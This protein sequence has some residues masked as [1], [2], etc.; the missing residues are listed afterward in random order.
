MGSPGNGSLPREP[1]WGSAAGAM[2]IR[3]PMLSRTKAPSLSRRAGLSPGSSPKGKRRASPLMTPVCT[4]DHDHFHHGL[5]GWLK[6][7]RL[8]GFFGFQRNSSFFLA[9]VPKG[10]RRRLPNEILFALTALAIA[11]PVL[12]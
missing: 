8:S 7:E 9:R 1:T 10:P 12:S 6:A 5:N 11:T 2:M 3:A 4:V